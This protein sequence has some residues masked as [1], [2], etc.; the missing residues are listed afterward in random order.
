MR[1]RSICCL[2][3]TLVCSACSGPDSAAPELPQQPEDV[4]AQKPPETAP[5]SQQPEATTADDW[6]PV[7]RDGWYTLELGGEAIDVFRDEFGTPHVFAPSV[8]AAFRAQGYVVMEDRPKQAL[9]NRAAARGL[10]ALV[11]GPDGIDHD[12]EVHLK[13][14]TDAE[15]QAQVDGLSG[16][17]RGYLEAYV[18]GI[19]DYLSQHA[20]PDVRSWDAVDTAAYSV[21]LVNTFGDGGSEELAIYRLAETVKAM[22][23]EDFLRQI[24][25]DCIPLDVP[26]APTTDHSSEQGPKIEQAVRR[27]A[28]F[29]PSVV[30]AALERRARAKAF[31]EEFGVMTQWGSNAWVVAPKR[32]ANGH[33]MLFGGPMMGFGTPS[34]CLQVHLVA[35]GMNV[36]G[37]TFPGVP[38]ILIGH[39]DRVAWTT[40][41]GGMNHTD[42]FV[43]ELNPDNKLQYMHNGQWED[44]V[45]IDVPISVR[46]DDGS[47]IQQPLTQHRTVHGPVIQWDEKNGRAYTRCTSHRGQELA[48][49]LSFLKYD[50]AQNFDDFEKGVRGVASTHNFFAADVDGNIGYWLAGLHPT[51]HPD[52][53]PRLPTPGTGEFDWTGHTVITD[54]VRSINPE[55][56]WFGNWN[57][58]PSIHTPSWFPEMFWGNKINE[59]LRENDPITWDTFLGIN[60][61][62]ATNDFLAGY[63]KPYLVSVV[64]AREDVSE[65]V[66][67]AAELVQAW[68]NENVPGGPGALVFHEW[69]LEVM[70]TLCQPGFGPLV[71]RSMDMESLRIFGPLVHRILIPADSGIEL[72]GDYLHGRDKDGVTYEAFEK[73]VG[74]LAAEH[75]PDMGQWPYEP[76]KGPS[77]GPLGDVPSR[78][79]GTYC[80]AAQLSTPITA[81]DVL[82]PGQSEHAESPHYGDQLE[83][84][85]DWQY[86]PIKHM[87]GDFGR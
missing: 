81:V 73:V 25:H 41:S 6:A 77:F 87:P 80:M 10:T 11:A 79:V 28:D 69:F 37:M 64:E 78:S 35:P 34:V 62:N 56:G 40:T 1:T 70:V 2:V 4:V 57:N 43:E 30:V 14:Q 42:I 49:L 9:K 68:E 50:F 48:G 26:N 38:G 66:Q 23:G 29:E 45:A 59:T 39:N 86:K 22:K 7:P 33:A 32:S 75:G 13:G 27:H 76:R 71:Q 8:N 63:L 31:A 19:N 58:K 24:L 60:E 65:D 67:K 61:A 3:L 74:Q 51:R 83:L 21:Y 17:S 44:M 54:K 12:T 15:L 52:Q 55:E 47:V 36:T 20:P 18:A 84:F 5:E 85:R 53:D 46:Q 16:D 72:Q 82:P